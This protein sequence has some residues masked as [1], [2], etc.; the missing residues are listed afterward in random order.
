ML[1][2]NKIPAQWTADGT[3]HF[4]EPRPEKQEKITAYL[5]NRSRKERPDKNHQYAER[6]A[7]IN[8]TH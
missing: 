3:A 7:A 2:L 4:I 5:L 1:L 6:A 8:V